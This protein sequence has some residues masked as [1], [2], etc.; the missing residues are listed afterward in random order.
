MWCMLV[1]VMLWLSIRFCHVDFVKHSFIHMLVHLNLYARQYFLCWHVLHKYCRLMSSYTERNIERLD[2]HLVNLCYMLLFAIW[3]Q[4]NVTF[5]LD[6]WMKLNFIKYCHNLVVMMQ[7]T[8]SFSSHS[9]VSAIGWGVTDWY[10]SHNFG[11]LG[12]IVMLLP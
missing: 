11:E 12:T 8:I 1:H 5:L 4:D 6:S 7:W 3:I 2:T 10:Q 9:D